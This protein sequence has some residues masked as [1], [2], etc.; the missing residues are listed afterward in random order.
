MIQF[1]EMRRN[2]SPV[3]SGI[4]ALKGGGVKASCGTCLKVLPEFGLAGG[5]NYVC[6]TC[7]QN[8]REEPTFVGTISPRG[9]RRDPEAIIQE[10]GAEKLS[11]TPAG[12]AVLANAKAKYPELIQRGEPGFEAYWGKEVRKR[13]KD[14]AE[15]R[16][17]SQ[18][19]KREAGMV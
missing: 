1:N 5:L 3:D 12:R 18:R 11:K 9:K 10:Y 15:V 14:M 17:E 2:K 4:P 7:S 16:S 8:R 6:K 13:E 19:L